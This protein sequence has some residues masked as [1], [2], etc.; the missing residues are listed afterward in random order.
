[1]LINIYLILFLIVSGLIFS[2]HNT[3][4]NRLIYL[5]ISFVVLISVAA[6]RSP[7]W[8]TGTYNIDTLGYKA[9]FIEY[10]NMEWSQIRD[11]FFARFYIR[12]SE[13]DVGFVILNK[14]IG[15]VTDE[16]YVYSLIV[17]LIFFIPF[18]TIL[19]RYTS[20][21]EQLI[22]AMVYYVALIQIFFLGGGRQMFAIGF[23]L[24][25]LL[26]IINRR[27]FIAI[28]L[29]VV[30]MSI[31]ISSFIFIA[32]L[33]L[34]YFQIKPGNLKLI[35]IISFMLF[36]LVLSFPN[37][38]ILFMGEMTEMEKFRIYGEGAIQ[39]NATTFIVLM[40]A[41]SLFIM[42]AISKL[43]LERIRKYR[44]FY[45]MMPFITFF[46]PLIHSNGSMIRITLYFSIF[47]TLLVPYGIDCVFKKYRPFSYVASIGAL[48]L[49]SLA[50]GGINYY[51]F[52]Q[53]LPVMY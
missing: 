1:M 29:V 52:W 7:E 28:L 23:D 44:I 33:L 2:I 30:G 47:L 25:A 48:S 24:M 32:P 49:L 46:A 12:E 8:M 53:T 3:P 17:D 16:F 18:G 13:S 5:I 38:I 9:S 6:L 45:T 26:N 41:L 11:L 10:S 22:F 43:D 14:L 19:Y 15:Y 42:F 21:M 20:R 36:P 4:R 31:H 39:G 35:H 51:F 34:I 50:N 40:E 27:L 37:Q